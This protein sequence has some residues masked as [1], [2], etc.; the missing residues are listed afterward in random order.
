MKNVEGLGILVIETWPK[1]YFGFWPIFAPMLHMGSIACMDP[2]PP[3]SCGYMSRPSPQPMAQNR[4][5]K[6]ERPGPSLTKSD[7]TPT[8]VSKALL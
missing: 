6:S 8:D 5:F 2:E 1:W 4:V 7:N 3:T